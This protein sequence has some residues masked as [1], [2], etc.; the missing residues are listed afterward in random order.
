MTDK[1]LFLSW[2][3]KFKI[4]SDQIRDRGNTAL[5]TACIAFLVHCKHR[6]GVKGLL[7]I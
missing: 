6:F 2:P 3:R 4:P 7:C 5:K 1:V